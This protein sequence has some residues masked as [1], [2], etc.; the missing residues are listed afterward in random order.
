MPGG[1]QKAPTVEKLC[2]Q[3]PSTSKPW[4]EWGKSPW[5][6]SALEQEYLPHAHQ[7]E[8]S[9]RTQG[10]K[11]VAKSRFG[12]ECGIQVNHSW[13]PLGE[14]PGAIATGENFGTTV[15]AGSN[16]S[17]LTPC[18]LYL[19]PCLPLKPL[20]PYNP[21]SRLPGWVAYK[22]N[23]NLEGETA[24]STPAS[25]SCPL[26]WHAGE[27]SECGKYSAAM[28]SAPKRAESLKDPWTTKQA[29]KNWS[30]KRLKK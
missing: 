1:E 28:K 18:P 20:P 30:K 23:L 27:K 21:G 8:A 15:D 14:A 11:A 7:T 3:T 9:E 16:T 5:K 2:W 22:C 13:W 25:F 6:K 17:P 26:K 10:P 29:E 4:V 19:P 24:I 12:T